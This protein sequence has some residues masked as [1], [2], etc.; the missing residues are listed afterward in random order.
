VI[1]VS[2]GS[3]GELGDY[4]LAP[5]GGSRQPVSQQVVDQGLQYWRFRFA[6]ITPWAVER[7]VLATRDVLRQAG[8]GL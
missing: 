6:E 5:G 8:I 4:V 3:D 7:M 2:T 1:H